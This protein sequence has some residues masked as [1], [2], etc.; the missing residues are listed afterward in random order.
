MARG[1]FA[2]VGGSDGVSLDTRPDD[3]SRGQTTFEYFGYGSNMSLTSLRAKG[4]VPVASRRATLRG[5]ELRF[6]VHHWFR[7]E[8]GVGNVWPSEAPGAAVQG[9]V[10]R[11]HRDALDSLDAVESF[12][13]GYDRITVRLDT[14]EGPVEAVTYVGIPNYLD[15]RCRPTRRYLNILVKG[16]VAAG[17]DADYIEALRRHPLHPEED[18]PEFRHPAGGGAV[19]TRES[20]AANPHLTAVGGAVFDMSGARPKHDCLKALLGGRDTT[21]FHLKRLDT[22]DG[23]ETLGDVRDDRLSAAQRRYLNA[24]LHGYAEEYQYVGRYSFDP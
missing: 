11:C 4:V 12:G 7:H 6:N 3:T 2:R 19:F 16:A 24:Y 17:L 20:L 13:V 5:Y 22:S 8:G 23:T 10:H 9:V 1:T 14:T 21:L 15:H 18:L